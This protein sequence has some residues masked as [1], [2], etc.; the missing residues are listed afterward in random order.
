MDGDEGPR[1]A[2]APGRRG[3]A[4]P[5]SGT[6]PTADPAADAADGPAAAPADPAAEYTAEQYDAFWGAGYTVEDAEALAAL[7]GTEITET[8]ARAGQAL[9]DGQT[10]PVAPGSS[11]ATS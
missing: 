3:R 9:L 1:R 11:T 2:A 7:W 5:P 4:G 8:K 6:A 10:L